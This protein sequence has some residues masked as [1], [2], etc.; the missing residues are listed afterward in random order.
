MYDEKRQYIEV[1]ILSRM[2]FDKK[3]S[4][5]EQVRNRDTVHHGDRACVAQRDLNDPGPFRA[6]VPRHSET[7]RT[8]G[9]AGVLYHPENDPRAFER[10][11]Q[12]PMDRNGRRFLRRYEDDCSHGN[13]VDTWPP[14]DEDGDDLARYE[15]RHRQ[16]R[17]SV[18]K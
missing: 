6:I 7:G 4:R 1:P 15:V 3:A 11:P 2:D 9:V 16:V 10:A 14:R 17:K 13:R 5:V 12:E 8:Y 18:K